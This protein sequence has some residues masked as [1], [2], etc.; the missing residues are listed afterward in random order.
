M[1]VHPTITS[2]VVHMGPTMSVSIRRRFATLPTTK[3]S[4]GSPTAES[5]DRT[6]ITGNMALSVNRSC[7]N[8]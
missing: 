4:S 1:N 8:R 2:V 5:A 3:Q 6:S 7:A